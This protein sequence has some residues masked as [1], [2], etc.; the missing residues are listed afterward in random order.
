[1]LAYNSCQKV[2]SIAELCKRKLVQVPLS[3][4]SFMIAGLFN[5]D[6]RWN[7]F[8]SC[9]SSAQRVKQSVLPP[10]LDVLQFLLEILFLPLI[11]T[12]NLQSWCCQVRSMQSNKTW[13]CTKMLHLQ[14]YKQ[15]FS[16]LIFLKF[17]FILLSNYFW[18]NFLWK[19]L[20][21]HLMNYNKFWSN[22]NSYNWKKVSCWRGRTLSQRLRTHTM[23]F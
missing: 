9:I 4:S 11:S 21:E 23:V 16:C 15:V 7:C 6:R 13:R 3:H 5:R 19:I 10:Q 2:A 8:K 20:I 18:M 17:S 14:D 22:G 12:D 1:M